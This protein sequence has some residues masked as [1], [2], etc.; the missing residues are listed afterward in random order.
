M[1]RVY[2]IKFTSILNY[3]AECDENTYG[4]NC[5]NS[6]GFCLDGE[7]CHYIDGRCLNG[8]SSGYTG[9]QCTKS[10]VYL[11]ILSLMFHIRIYWSPLKIKVHQN[12]SVRSKSSTQYH[13]WHGFWTMIKFNT[14]VKLM[15]CYTWV[16][17]FLLYSGSTIIV[18]LA[19]L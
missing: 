9:S 17:F 2:F 12:K 8:C 10:T 3:F 18:I 14:M 11:Y 1:Y 5:S 16:I 19:M 15:T 7:Q 6:C 13:N 4:Q